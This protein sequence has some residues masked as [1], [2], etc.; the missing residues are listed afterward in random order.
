MADALDLTADALTLEREWKTPDRGTVGIIFLIITESALFCIFV[1]VYLIYI[2]ASTAGPYPKD[3]LERPYLAT[4]C[5]LSSS[6][7]IM[8]AEHYLKKN[9]LGQFKLWWIV[10]IL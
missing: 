5:L 6:A 4:I 3:V 1:A 9:E 10:T 2:G 8:F 7:T